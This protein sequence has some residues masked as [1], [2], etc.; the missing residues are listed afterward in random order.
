M[1]SR[2]LLLLKSFFKEY[3]FNYTESK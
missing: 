2:K 1:L 3:S